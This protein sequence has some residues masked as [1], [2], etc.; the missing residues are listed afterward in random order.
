M[1]YE[2]AYKEA[3]ERAKKYYNERIT[4]GHT[5]D[6][7]K[8]IFPEVKDDENERIKNSLIRWFKNCDSPYFAG[9]ELSKIVDWLE[10]Q[11]EPKQEWSEEDENYLQSAE[12][13]CDYQ[14]GK[15]TSTIL[16]LKSLKDRL[17][18]VKNC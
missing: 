8:E 2:K 10:K 18:S 3:L 4:L 1:N 15:N 5:R 17:L 12:N 16:W 13:T 11:G 9:F 7:I 6:V 14:Y